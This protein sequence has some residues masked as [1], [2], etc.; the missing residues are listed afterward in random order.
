[1]SRF[2]QDRQ[3]F[4]EIDKTCAGWANVLAFSPDAAAF[5]KTRTVQGKIR[6]VESKLRELRARL[7]AFWQAPPGSAWIRRG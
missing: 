3:E 2:S 7:R 6:R 1:L 5:A 4:R